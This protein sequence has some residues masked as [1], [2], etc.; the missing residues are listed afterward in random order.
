MQSAASRRSV[1]LI[2]GSFGVGKTT[3]A[4]ALRTRAPGA[5]IYDPEWIGSAIRRLPRWIALRGHGTDDFQ[6]IAIWRKSVA[7][8]T[9]VFGAL[10]TGPVIVPMT[11]SNLAYLDEV[12]RGIRAFAPDTRVFCLT[13]SLDCIRQRLIARGTPVTGPEASWIQRRTQQCVRAHADPRFGELIDTKG[14]SVTDI[15]DRITTSLD[16]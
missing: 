1:V 16:W 15:V 3:V 4:R 14:R 9:R 5:V 12:L 13:A 2:N 8:G 10:T 7:A 11:F 6:D